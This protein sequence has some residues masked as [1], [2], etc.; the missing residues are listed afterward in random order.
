MPGTHD[1]L[2][3]FRSAGLD[4]ALF[5]VVRL[6]GREA[7]SDLY[8]FRLELTSKDPDI[9]VG[10]VL[11]NNATIEMELG[12]DLVY[13]HGIVSTFVQCDR[14]P[15][16]INYEALLVPRL[17]TL[18]LNQQCQILRRRTRL[19]VRTPTSMARRE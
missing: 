14:G 17:Y 5:N 9:D 10:G 1:V 4:E 8:E 13:V 2:F 18:G 15:E 16:W 3:R 11:R 6:D 12:G 7:L 19:I